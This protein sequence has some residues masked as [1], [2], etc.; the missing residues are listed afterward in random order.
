M[1]YKKL[2]IF[3]I[4]DIK[5]KNKMQRIP[6]FMNNPIFNEISNKIKI[7]YPNSCILFIDE[8]I[9]KNLEEHYELQKSLVFETRG[10][11]KEELL[12]HGTRADLINI[13]ALEGFDPLKN[14]TSSYGKGTYFAKNANYS[15]N[16]MKTKDKQGISYMFL[17]KVIIGK[18]E[19]V[20]SN[21][22]EKLDYDILVNNKENPTIFV[23]QYRYGA[24]PKYIIAFHKEAV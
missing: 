9:N 19:K 13:I 1:I 14:I 18:I 20:T 6:I 21:A 10:N 22:S 5:N 23:T 24:Y 12:F 3:Y 17:C 11:V 2:I 7:S 15:M 8:V 16:Y 4:F